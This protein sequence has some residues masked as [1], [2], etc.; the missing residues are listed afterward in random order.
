MTTAADPRDA[1]HDI[2]IDK[3]IHASGRG[4]IVGATGIGKTRIAIK[5]IKLIQKNHA[6]A[7]ILIVVPTIQLRDEDW[8]NELEALGVNTEYIKIICY[9]MLANE[10]KS[11]TLVILDEGH[12]ITPPRFEYFN[13]YISLF[14]LTLTAT[15]P[16][17][18]ND[19]DVI[20]A[21]LL[22][23]IS[24][25]VFTMK[26]DEAA[27]KGLIAD[28]EIH[29]L[30]FPLDDVNKTIKAGTAKKPFYTTEA[31]H[32]EYLSKKLESAQIDLSEKRSELEAAEAKL[33]L[34]ANAGSVDKELE[35]RVLK[36]DSWLST[37]IQERTRFIY[38]LPSRLRLAKV[39]LARLQQD[40]RRTLCFGSSIPFIE[41]LVPH[42][43]YHSKT[44][45][46]ALNMFQEQKISVLGAV[47][48]LNE[49][50][51]LTLIDNILAASIDAN[52]R[53]M[54]QRAGR[55]VR[56]RPG[57]K[58][59]MVVLVA[60]GT[61]DEKWWDSASVEFDAKRIQVREVSP[62]VYPI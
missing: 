20:K 5:A 57:H 34:F 30:K 50:K 10:E 39:C 4:C 44:D 12:H 14:V 3:W 43:T 2:A 32:Y 47:Q 59:L 42:Y 35:T 9:N 45:D 58:L 23:A 60:L 28:F 53:N 19:D 54:V 38:N 11:Y 31:K 29:V 21:K 17:D 40:G 36:A 56:P 27:D 18:R 52:P 62:T 1:V 22:N 8:P 49:G 55:G 51:N 24:P 46:T 37:C 7:D 33:S 13:R 41:S 16:G 15:F 61:S 26:L 25:V 48:A 6:M